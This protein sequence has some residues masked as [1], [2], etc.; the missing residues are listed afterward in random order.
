[1]TPLDELRRLLELRERAPWTR[2]QAD[3]AKT[4][5]GTIDAQGLMQEWQ[6]VGMSDRY[7]PAQDEDQSGW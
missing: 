6:G 7:E 5:V 1:M 4:L 3:R 2:P